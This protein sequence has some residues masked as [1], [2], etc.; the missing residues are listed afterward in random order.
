MKSI[1]VVI[2]GKIYPLRIQEGDEAKVQQA[3]KN[4]KDSVNFFTQN[5]EIKHTQDPLAMTALQMAVQALESENQQAPQQNNEQE[6]NAIL[7]MLNQ[8]SAENT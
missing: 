8:H 2:L 3:V 7:N 1:E 5:Y 4:I 6:L